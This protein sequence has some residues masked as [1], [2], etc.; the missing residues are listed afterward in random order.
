MGIPLIYAV[1]KTAA[2]HGFKKAIQ[3]HG[4]ASWQRA[5]KFMGPSLSDKQVEV[6]AGDKFLK[7][8]T[9]QPGGFFAKRPTGVAG[10]KI[11]KKL[12]KKA[13]S[14]AVKEKKIT[15]PT[16]Q[17]KGGLIHKYHIGGFVSNKPKGVGLAKRGWGAVSR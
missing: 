4:L 7:I 9:D 15:K 3:K 14:K 6:R 12:E 17:K 8:L 11:L 13:V 10:K 2:I 1:L 16:L 5:K